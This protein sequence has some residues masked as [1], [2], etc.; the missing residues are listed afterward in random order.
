M[1]WP[2][3]CWGGLAGRSVAPAGGSLAGR[4]VARAGG[5]GGDGWGAGGGEGG[6]CRDTTLD[7]ETGVS[8]F[9]ATDDTCRYHIDPVFGKVVVTI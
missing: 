8:L 2:G 5:G 3:P 9:D 4:S 6:L 1:L 7:A